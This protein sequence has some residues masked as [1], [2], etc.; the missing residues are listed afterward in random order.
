MAAD[1]WGRCADG[2]L[3]FLPHPAVGYGK[4][5]PEATAYKLSASEAAAFFAW[6]RVAFEGIAGFGP[7]ARLSSLAV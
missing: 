1:Y 4:R 7:R 3:A 2:A 6:L 5:V